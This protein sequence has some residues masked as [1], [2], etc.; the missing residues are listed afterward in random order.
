MSFAAT[1]RR[2][3]RLAAT[4]LAVLFPSALSAQAITKAEIEK[5]R[6]TMANVERLLTV[7][8]NMKALE[9]DA[10]L[11]K[12]AAQNA[13]EEGSEAGTENNPNA[14]AEGLTKMAAK[15]SEQPKVRQAVQSAGI[16]PREYALTTYAL[17]MSSMPVAAE[18][19]YGKTVDT[20]GLAPAMVANIELV[21][22][23]WTRINAMGEEMK[24]YE[25]KKPEAPGGEDEG[26]DEGEKDPA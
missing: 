9:N 15:L 25:M 11:Q 3:A 24:K 18:K 1:R 16:T 8:R 6:L 5:Y 21:R 26:D 7:A 4:L 19:Q 2:T 14:E 13:R 10:E 22:A 23:N 17:L 12:W 20:K